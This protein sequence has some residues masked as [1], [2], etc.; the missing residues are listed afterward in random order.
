MDETP[1]AGARGR[2]HEIGPGLIVDL[3][4][5]MVAAFDW[6][7]EVAWRLTLSETLRYLTAKK[8]VE[9][10]RILWASRIFMMPLAKAGDRALLVE[11]LKREMGEKP[12]T[13][14]EEL[15]PEVAAEVAEL[16]RR[17]KAWL[18]EQAERSKKR[19]RRR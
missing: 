16:E 9:I 11:K 14:E 17:N 1:G 10:M 4:A 5:Q 19:K 15:G 18:Q 13:V 3:H 6:T 7:P 2:K 8:R 12:L